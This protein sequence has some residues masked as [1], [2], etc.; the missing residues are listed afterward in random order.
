MR[1][2]QLYEV[3]RRRSSI[4]A[5]WLGPEEGVPNVAAVI[6]VSVSGTIHTG[7]SVYTTIKIFA[8]I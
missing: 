3:T 5:P 7:Q 2:E 4:G 8:R 1:W 6:W